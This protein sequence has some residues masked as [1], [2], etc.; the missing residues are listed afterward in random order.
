MEEKPPIKKLLHD[1]KGP[2]TVVIGFLQSIENVEKANAFSDY[3]SAAIKSADKMNEL[4]N[5]FED[6][7]LE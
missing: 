7:K 2:L 3:Y 4:I 5:K 6:G 1:L